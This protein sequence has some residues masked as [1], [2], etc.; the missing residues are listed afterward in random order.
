MLALIVAATTAFKA[1]PSVK[2]EDR[3]LTYQWFLYD[4]SG[5]ITDMS[6]YDYVDGVDP[7]C[8]A[9]F[10]V[11]AIKVLADETTH[12]INQADFEDLRDDSNGFTVNGTY[13]SREVDEEPQP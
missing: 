6:S 13:G 8:N 1:T 2:V 11:C 10:K 5:T 9:T 7:E 12:A 4:G 3:L